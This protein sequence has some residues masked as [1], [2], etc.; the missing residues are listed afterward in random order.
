MKET[1]EANKT[2]LNDKQLQAID[3]ILIGNTDDQVAKHVGVNRSTVCQ[4]RNHNIYF[5]AELNKRRKEIWEATSDRLRSLA[6]KAMD[7]VET[8]IEQGDAKI[9]LEVLKLAGLGKEYLNKIGEDDPK[10]LEYQKE[11][12]EKEKEQFQE[13]DKMFYKARA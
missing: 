5:Q 3:L 9:A 13:L 8:A 7:T 10:E 4:W 1:P 2:Q 11:M 6:F 12:K